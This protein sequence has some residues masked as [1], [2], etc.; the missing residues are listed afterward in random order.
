[1]TFGHI[2]MTFVYQS[3]DHV[4]HLFQMMRGVRLDIGSQHAQRTH[5]LMIGMRM[6]G[7]DVGDIFSGLL[8]RGIDLVVDIGD[9][10]DV[11][12]VVTGPQQAHEHIEYHRRP[13]ITNVRTIVDRRPTDVDGHPAGFERD[14]F[15]FGP[16]ER[17]VEDQAHRL[18]YRDVSRI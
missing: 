10:A 4:D 1:M 8:C 6:P 2:G 12:H 16:P 15:F 13:R 17:V 7:R 18:K 5:V 11:G 14:K 3:G 9:V